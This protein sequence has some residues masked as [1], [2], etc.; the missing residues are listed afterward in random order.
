MLTAV[1]LIATIS[2]CRSWSADDDAFVQIY[3]DILILREQ[4]PDTA[5][6][7]AKMRL[8]LAKRG[9]TESNFQAQ[10][11]RYASNP[12]TFRRMI[13]SSRALLRRIV[14]QERRRSSSP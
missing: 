8:L 5:I 2:A 11:R 9:W 7:N 12:D 4:H 6:A 3:T 1:T 10:Y 14:E 13:D